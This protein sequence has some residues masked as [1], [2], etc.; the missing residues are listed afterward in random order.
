[1]AIIAHLSKVVK[2]CRFITFF[3]GNVVS[4][5]CQRAENA[6]FLARVEETEMQWALLGVWMGVI[7]AGT[8]GPG[9]GRWLK[10]CVAFMLALS[11]GTQLW[12]L[13]L[14]GLLTLETAL[15]LHLCGLFGVLSIPMLLWG[16]PA[17][18]YEASVFLAAPAAFCTLFFPAVIACSHPFWMRLAF[19]RL[20]VLL[21][22]MPLL[23]WRTGKPLP[24]DPRR[25]FLLGN[26]Y[27]LAIGAFNRA[28]HTN[29]LFLRA[30]PAGTPLSALFS[31]GAPFYIGALEMLCMLAFVWLKGIYGHCR[32]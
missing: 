14:D 4:K 18:L 29:Y 6:D 11:M 3:C 12:L 31:R 15:P 2:S 7:W 17:P 28:F 13:K 19:T 16:A 21:A 1:M 8:R 24:T 22:L 32:K 23:F 9:E 27:L 5:V 20:H 30:A 25:T 26:G 10:G